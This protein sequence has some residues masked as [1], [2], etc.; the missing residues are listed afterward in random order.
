MDGP[1]FLG[2]VRSIVE[3]LVSRVAH[4][5]GIVV[6]S[7]LPDGEELVT[8]LI[9]VVRTFHA[10]LAIDG[11]HFHIVAEHLCGSLGSILIRTASSL[12]SLLGSFLFGDLELIYAVFL[13][14][15]HTVSAV[16]EAPTE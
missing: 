5:V 1:A 14:L 4:K 12:G 6:E 10:T 9:G 3:R 8:C 15:L 11:Q 7:S 16:I 13:E 2:E